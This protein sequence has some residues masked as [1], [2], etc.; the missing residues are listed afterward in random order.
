MKSHEQMSF[1]VFWHSRIRFENQACV[2]NI[3]KK[4][5]KN[6]THKYILHNFATN[7]E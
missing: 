4:G 2:K 5:K 7:I 3:Q 6:F 1:F